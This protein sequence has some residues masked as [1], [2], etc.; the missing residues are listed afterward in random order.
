MQQLGLTSAGNYGLLIAVQRDPQNAG[1]AFA[2]TQCEARP[3]ASVIAAELAGENPFAI[4]ESAFLHSAEP[5]DRR[6]G[7]FRT[8][9]D[10]QT[11]SGQYVLVWPYGEEDAMRRGGFVAALAVKV[12]GWPAA[13]FTAPSWD[14]MA[15]A[16]VG[17]K[18]RTK[19]GLL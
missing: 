1:T 11:F 9:F 18:P 2:S 3:L 5:N 8:K 6:A 14:K 15:G 4:H 7:H 10:R 17:V 13:A 16:M 19:A 12:A